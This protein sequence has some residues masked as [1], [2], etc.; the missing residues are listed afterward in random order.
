M[1]RF[2]FSLFAAPLA[3][4]FALLCPSSSFAAAE[5]EEEEQTALS[6]PNAIENSSD[7]VDEWQERVRKSFGLG[8]WG[9][10]DG[11]IFAFASKTAAF[12]A[13]DQQF[14]GS[15][16]AAFELAMED[17]QQQVT[18]LRFGRI[19]VEK[20]REFF[21][22]NSSDAKDVPLEA[23]ARDAAFADKAYAILDKSLDLA[24]A[25][26]DKE[27][28]S[29]GVAP[30]EIENVPVKKKKTLF[31]EL[32]VKDMAKTAAGDIAGIFPIQ[33][34][35][36]ID[37]NGYATVGVVAVFS[38]KT[39]QV[40][41]DVAAQRRPIV[42]GKGRD[43][44]AMVPKDVSENLGS[45]G[46]RLVYDE[47]GEPAIVSYAVAAYVPDG[48]DAFFNSRRKDSARKAAIDLADAQLA[49]TVSGQMSVR[50]DRTTG[51]SVEKFVERE[52]AAGSLSFEKDAK[53]IVDTVKEY[54]KARAGMLLQGVSTL[55]TKF[56][57][58]PSGQQFYSVVRVWKFSTLKAVDA[59][60]RG[61]YEPPRAEAKAAG[62]AAGSPSGVFEGAKH[63][64]LEDF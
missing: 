34:T 55:D 50:N 46:T 21:A 58:I 42:T 41:R 39:V 20:S 48:D 64:T 63:N 5:S 40:A 6:D 26:L 23:T 56:F 27:L 22:D 13:T 17:I 9:E 36:V 60:N 7:S 49:E 37:K 18:M 2:A 61:V 33:S 45:L 54:S 53:K 4:G 24:G 28:A 10:H 59:V 12:P 3:L 32:F 14:G 29:L 15:L 35:V 31:K 16:A 38:P 25:K 1:K 51:Q 30:R 52:M 44:S 47:N 62:G 43:L 11:K 57:K 19:A 8:D